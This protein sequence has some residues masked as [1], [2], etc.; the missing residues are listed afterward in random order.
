MTQPNLAIL[1]DR[2]VR[3][4]HLSLSAKA[5]V[6]DTEKV[7]PGGAIFLLTLDEMGT[8]P[9]HALTE[10]LMRDK[11]QMTRLVRSLER[12][13]LIARHA[14]ADDARVTLISLTDAGRG[15][16]VTHLDA[17]AET[18]DDLLAPLSASEST[19]F[20]ELLTRAV[21]PSADP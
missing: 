10:R 6:F 12:K 17:V 13:G 11:S 20:R 15:V 7:G 19:Q 4:M 8:V 5:A 21:A 18:L 3:R 2:F 9:L 16:V 1:L 14:C